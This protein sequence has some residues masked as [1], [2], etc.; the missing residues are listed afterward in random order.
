MYDKYEKLLKERNITSFRVSK[1]TG[2]AQS[3]LAEWKSGRSQPKLD[4]LIKLSAY[5]QV[6]IEYFIGETGK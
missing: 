5:F 2:I 6:P 1:D 3:T 4:K